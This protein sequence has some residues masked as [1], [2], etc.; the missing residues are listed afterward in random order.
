MIEL[1]LSQSK[2]VQETSWSENGDGGCQRVAVGGASG[3]TLTEVP[4]LKLPKQSIC[5]RI[6]LSCPGRS[7]IQAII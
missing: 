7:V 1:C 5:H 6:C 4:E 2:D 3:C